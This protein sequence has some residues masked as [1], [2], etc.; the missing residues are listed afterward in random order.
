MKK[1]T[2]PPEGGGA[3]K[4]LNPGSLAVGLGTQVSRTP[5][6]G[7]RDVSR[8]REGRPSSRQEHRIP[9]RDRDRGV[10]PCTEGRRNDRTVLPC[11][12][13]TGLARLCRPV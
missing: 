10:R 1:E 7:R 9:N 2:T 8:T 6:A 11:T 4:G 5:P 3:K 13:V 12:R